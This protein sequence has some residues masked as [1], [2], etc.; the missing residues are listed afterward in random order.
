[1]FS[2]FPFS[3]LLKLALYKAHFKLYSAYRP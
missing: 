2:N 1:M 3:H